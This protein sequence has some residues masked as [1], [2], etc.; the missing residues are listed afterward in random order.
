MKH[1]SINP[2]HEALSPSSGSGPDD[3]IEGPPLERFAR[4]SA[5]LADPFADRARLLAAY[6]FDEASWRGLQV[7]WETEIGARLLV[8]DGVLATAYSEAFTRESAH[9]REARS[10]AT[11]STM[12][13]PPTP[14]ENVD[15]TMASGC[16]PAA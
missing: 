1:S 5:R 10:S 2:G 16:T 8:G 13:A 14:P 15:M 7:Q 11:T 4:L 6:G 12:A 9:L 3:R